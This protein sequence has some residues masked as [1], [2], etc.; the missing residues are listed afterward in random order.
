M[1]SKIIGQ[2]KA[3]PDIDGWYESE[4]I[5]ISLLGGHE[6]CL[7]IEDTDEDHNPEEFEQAI[8]NFMALTESLKAEIEPH[9]YKHYLEFKEAVASECCPTNIP[10][11]SDVWQFIYP[12]YVNV[13]RRPYGNKGVYVQ[14]LGEC[15]WEPEHGLQVVF[16][17]G[18]SLNRVSD[19][20]G[21]LTYSDAYNIPENQDRIC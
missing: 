12:S 18:K 21:H 7:T 2:L 10:N 20:D 4:A 16:Q 17:N 1:D 3:H 15:E 9:I 11:Q 5:A 6:L 13:S 8:C 14:L 19:Q